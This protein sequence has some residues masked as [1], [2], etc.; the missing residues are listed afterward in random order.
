MADEPL[1]PLEYEGRIINCHSAESRQLL[2]D[3]TMIFNDNSQAVVFIS[4][5][6]E[7]R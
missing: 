2:S 4:W 1:F 5:L 6:A 3:A 7:F